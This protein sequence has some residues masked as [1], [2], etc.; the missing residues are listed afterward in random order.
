MTRLVRTAAVAWVIALV[1]T[2]SAG[3]V[4]ASPDANT[5][6]DAAAQTSEGAISDLATVEQLLRLLHR[7]GVPRP[8]AVSELR[9]SEA[10]LAKS[11]DWFTSLNPPAGSEP[12]AVHLADLLETASGL[13]DQSRLAVHRHATDE[14]LPLAARLAALTNR[15]ERLDAGL[16]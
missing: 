5:Y 10:S 12:V 8:A 1:S 14:Y 7:D 6:R 3:C 11:S 9:T 15:L 16:S 13:V 2:G 4:V